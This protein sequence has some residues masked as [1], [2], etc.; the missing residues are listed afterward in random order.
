MPNELKSIY[1]YQ[2][3]W[4]DKESTKRLL[5]TKI[6]NN[7]EEMFE[8]LYKEGNSFEAIITLR[9]ITGI[10]HLYSAPEP[11]FVEADFEIRPIEE[12]TIT[13][14]SRCGQP[15]N[16]DILATV[17]ADNIMGGKFCPAC[18]LGMLHSYLKNEK[19]NNG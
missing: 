5:K 4:P 19:E 2:I 13:Q 12:V 17:M 8:V 9:N 14:C 10:E 1:R 16:D 3:R 6:I 11:S 18:V 15:C 7:F